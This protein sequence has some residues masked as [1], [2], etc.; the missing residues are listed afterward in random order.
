M[1]SVMFHLSHLKRAS[2]AFSGDKRRLRRPTCR[3]GAC[4]LIALACV[5]IALHCVLALFFLIVIATLVVNSYDL[6]TPPYQYQLAAPVGNEEMAGVWQFDEEHCS[7]FLTKEDREFISREDYERFEFVLNSDGSF[8]MKNLPPQ[9]VKRVS[10][11][12]DGADDSD[13][14]DERRFSLGGS[15][16]YLWCAS[17]RSRDEYAIIEGCWSIVKP[18][19]FFALDLV[20]EGYDF[21]FLLLTTDGLFFPYD[22]NLDSRCGIAFKK[23]DGNYSPDVLGPDDKTK[24]H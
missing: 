17:N 4:V 5:L 12:H 6:D 8:Q 2:I 23:K 1:Q 19:N 20:A 18:G 14:R 24:R 13:F 15:D 9:F 10:V 7:N 11:V 21:E 22:F 3:R 16:R